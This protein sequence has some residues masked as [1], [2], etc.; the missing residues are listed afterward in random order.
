M[1]WMG[2]VVI[3][4]GVGVF[5]GHVGGNNM[6]RHWASQITISLDNTFE[7][8][9]LG[10][11]SFSLQAAFFRP[12]V[13]HRLI[14]G[15]VCSFYFDPVSPLFDCLVGTKN[16]NWGELSHLNRQLKSLAQ[17]QNPIEAIIND[18]RPRHTMDPR[19][20]TVLANIKSGLEQETCTDRLVLAELVGMSASRFSHW[21][22]EQLGIPVRSYKKWLKLRLAIDA[23]L[24]GKAPIDA[25]H[26][27][28]FSDQ[29]H[30]SRA[31]AHAFGITY[32]SARTAIATKKVQ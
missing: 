12:N 2:N 11:G 16:E 7:V 30:M 1:N 23:M 14:H 3:A 8:E 4:D 29:A 25:A 32:M 24:N 18:F 22:V 21:F 19:I 20:N 17:A 27:A 10:E 28:G 5:R 9:V 31:F 26:S 6:H 13:G 15:N